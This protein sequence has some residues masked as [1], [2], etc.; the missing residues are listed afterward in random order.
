MSA[1]RCCWLV[2]KIPTFIPALRGVS[3]ESAPGLPNAG[4]VPVQLTLRQQ[5]TAVDINGRAGD[6]IV[7]DHKDDALRHLF[8]LAG[9][10]DEIVLRDVFIHLTARVSFEGNHRGVDGTWRDDVD[11]A[12]RKFAGNGTDQRFDGA[13]NRR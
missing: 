13:A 4:P 6:E 9:A 5:P 7:L 8:R 1:S 11:A 2:R 3:Q 12:W 10:R